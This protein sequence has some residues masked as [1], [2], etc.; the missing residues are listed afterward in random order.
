MR[1][2]V[3]NTDDNFLSVVQENV[4]I[5]KYSSEQNRMKKKRMLGL[6]YIGLSVN[7]DGIVE[8]YTVREENKFG[9]VCGSNFCKAANN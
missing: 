1:L 2:I 8:H 9:T 5:S 3:H 6:E 7:K 4:S